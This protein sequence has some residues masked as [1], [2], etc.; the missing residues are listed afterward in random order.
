MK[1]SLITLQALFEV[2]NEYYDAT[3]AKS[4]IDMNNHTDHLEKNM[5]KIISSFLA[6]QTQAP[7]LI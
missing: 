6:C 2:I 4:T 3:T 1:P 5:Y 7:L